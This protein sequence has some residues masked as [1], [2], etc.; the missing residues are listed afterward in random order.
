MKNLKVIV[1]RREIPELDQKGLRYF[2]WMSATLVASLFGLILPWLLN[3]D[4]PWEPWGISALFFVWGLIA[5]STLRPF[6][7]IWMRFG[8]VMNAIMT[9]VILG[10]VYYVVVFPTGLVFRLRGI[11]PLHRKWDR[12]LQSYRVKSSAARPIDMEKPF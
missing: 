1:V 8:F 12:K 7:R 2:A 10:A 4:W 3:R 6:Y 11:D 9:S 5:P